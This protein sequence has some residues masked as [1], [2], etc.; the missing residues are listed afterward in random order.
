M[1]YIKQGATPLVTLVGQLCCP[2]VMQQHFTD[3]SNAALVRWPRDV[4]FLLLSLWKLIRDCSP[5]LLK[6]D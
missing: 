4:A 5:Y 2:V 3:C 6:T 1:V